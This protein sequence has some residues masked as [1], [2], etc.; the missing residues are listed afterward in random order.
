[1]SKR[2][3]PCISLGESNELDG[4]YFM[5]L[6]TGKRLHSCKWIM[7]PM[8]DYVISQVNDLTEAENQPVMPGDM[9]TFQWAPGII[10]DIEDDGLEEKYNSEME[11]NGLAE[12]GIGVEDVMDVEENVVSKSDES[13]VL[14]DNV[15]GIVEP[16]EEDLEVEE[17]KDIVEDKEETSDKYEVESLENMDGVQHESDVNGE[18]MSK[19]DESMVHSSEYSF[20]ENNILSD[21]DSV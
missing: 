11:E 7:L 18:D 15:E 6:E 12:D 21:E 8:N 17:I 9:P 1:M 4:M 10:V 19:S 5:S 14:G 16:D 3:T 13:T 20:N 2:T